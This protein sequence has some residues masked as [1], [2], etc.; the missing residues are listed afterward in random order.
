[1]GGRLRPVAPITES[2]SPLRAGFLVP[3]PLSRSHHPQGDTTI[4]RCCSRHRC[5]RQACR[6][7]AGRWGSRALTAPHVAKLWPLLACC[8]SLCGRPAACVPAR[9]AFPT[10]TPSRCPIAG[11][12]S[13]RSAF[14]E[15]TRPKRGRRSKIVRRKTFPASYSTRPSRGSRVSIL[16][17]I[18]RVRAQAFAHEQPCIRRRVFSH[19]VPIALSAGA[20]DW[21]RQSSRRGNSEQVLH[22]FLLTAAP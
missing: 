20:D 19:R 15:L 10:A 18:S 7:S 4:S 2:E 12:S 13:T 5:Q 9:W 8:A 3:G 14:R 11:A 22:R 16:Q 17:C 1:M 6:L 21:T